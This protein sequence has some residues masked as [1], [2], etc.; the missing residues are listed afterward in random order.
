VLTDAIP[1]AEQNRSIY[2]TLIVGLSGCSIQQVMRP[3]RPSTC[4]ACG[5]AHRWGQR[6]GFGR[7]DAIWAKLS[8]PAGVQNLGNKPDADAAGNNPASN[9]GLR[10]SGHEQI[11]TLA[12]D[13]L[14][15][16]DTHVMIDNIHVVQR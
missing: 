2:D 10:G 9:V 16:N 14:P 13:I 8:E 15:D 3:L 11:A 1:A 6:T 7:L 5:H 4:H 12:L